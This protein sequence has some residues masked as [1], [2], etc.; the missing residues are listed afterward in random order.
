M[1]RGL[2]GTVVHVKTDGTH[3]RNHSHN[4]G[5]I[6]ESRQH[7]YAG[8]IFGGRS[9]VGMARQATADHVPSWSMR[10]INSPRVRTPSFR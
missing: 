4:T 1:Y 3:S 6:R 8:T 5:P 2:S 7:L 9:G 10:R